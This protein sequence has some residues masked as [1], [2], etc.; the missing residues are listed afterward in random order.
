MRIANPFSSS[1]RPVLFGNRGAVAAAH[2][3][4][5]SAA[6]EMLTAGGSAIDATIAA[7]AV[8]CVLS[9]DNCGLGGDQ[10]C[11]VRSGVGEVIAVNGTGA[12]PA[13]MNRADTDGGNSVSVPG[14]VDAWVEMGRRWGRLPLANILAPAIRLG[15]DGVLVSE[16]LAGTFAQYE[17]RLLRGGAQGWALRTAKAGRRQPQ[18][19]LARLLTDIGERGRAAFY[20]GP[21]A[22]AICGAI[23]RNGGVMSLADLIGNTSVVSPPLTTKW[24][25]MR[26]HVQPPI[27]QGVLLSMVLAAEEKL[28]PSAPALRDHIGVELTASSFTFRDRSG[29]GSALLSEPLTVDLEKASGR[30]GPRAY[31]HTA[32]VAVADRNG[33]VVSSLISVFDS[34]G[35]AVF[36][37]EGGFTLNNRAAGFTMAPNDCAGGKRP[38]HTLAPVLLETES[39]CLALATP[40]ADGQVQTLTQVLSNMFVGGDDLATAI[41][42]PRWRSQDGKLLVESAHPHGAALAAK[43]HEVELLQDGD[44]R[45]GAIVSAGLCG[46]QPISCADWRRETWAGVS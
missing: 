26:L 43:E 19:E 46:D 14:I 37:P 10:L 38:V 8:L 23:R 20:A 17:T 42:R 40:G 21:M 39:G 30:T 12:A 22:D 33:L 5:V 18:P 4:A 32:G 28:P 29:E 1:Q 31:L 44:L 35:S 15:E 25:G 6:T 45:F 13:A 41:A 24:R 9:P 11:L 34:F 36:V 3:L 7:Q 27:S 2:P 16:D